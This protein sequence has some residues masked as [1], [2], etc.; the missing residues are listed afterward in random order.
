[1]VQYVKKKE[2]PYKLIII[3]NYKEEQYNNILIE[4]IISQKFN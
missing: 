1:M 3:N 2:L 4:N